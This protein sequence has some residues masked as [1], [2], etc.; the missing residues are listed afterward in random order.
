MEA[1]QEIEKKYYD[2]VDQSPDGVFIIELSGNILTVNKAMCKELGFSEELLS[3]SIW[4]LILEQYLDQY[5]KRMAKVLDGKSFK[6]S[7]RI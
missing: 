6:G 2:L 5:R 1:L 4:E 7:S 3:M